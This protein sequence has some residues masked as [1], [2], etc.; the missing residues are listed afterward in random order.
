M[1]VSCR[2]L[3]LRPGCLTLSFECRMK[4]RP[5]RVTGWICGGVVVASVVACVAL[6]TMRCS[7]LVTIKVTALDAAAEPRDHNIPFLKQKEALPDYE[8]ALLLHDGRKV[9]LGSKPDTSAADGLV[10]QIANPVSVLDIA[11]VRLREQDKVVSDAIAEVQITGNTVTENGY[12][13]DFTQQRS[14]A[15]GVE[16]FF[17]TPIG[18]AVATG[19]C[20]AALVLVLS[21]FAA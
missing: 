13:F 15:V 21:V 4:S 14:V 8:L 12:R 11:A 1:I 7:G 5:W 6:A 18:K 16:S 17:G 9:H 2:C 3:C 20:I 19:F 10:W